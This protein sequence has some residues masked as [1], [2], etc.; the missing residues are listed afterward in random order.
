MKTDDYRE[1]LFRSTGKDTDI[2]NLDRIDVYDNLIGEIDRLGTVAELLESPG[3]E[4]LSPR[5]GSGLALLLGDIGARMRSILE[6]SVA[7]SGRKAT[8]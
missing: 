1:F 6:L 2:G 4:E 5:V 3:D 7:K 8:R